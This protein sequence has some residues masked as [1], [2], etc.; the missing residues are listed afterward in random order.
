M[1]IE[2]D[3]SNSPYFDDY[4]SNK[5]YYKVLFKPG[6]AVQVRELNQLQ[7]ILQSQIEKF[8]DN[9]YK[10][11]TIIDGVNFNFIENLP[12]IKIKDNTTTGAISD[13]IL[14]DKNF[15]VNDSNGLRAF[16][17]TYESG[18]ESQD[19]DLNT[20]FI[21]Y[22]NSGDNGTTS[23]Y[24]SGQILSVVDPLRSV[25]S[26]FLN[27]G[28]VGYVN[29]NPVII[30][31]ALSLQNSVG[32]TT[33]TN[34]SAGVSTFTVGE[35]VTQPYSGAKGTVVAIN[36]TAN[37]KSIV[38]QI[39]P[40][41]TDVI[42][43]TATSS[44]W[45]FVEGQSIQG[46][47]SNVTAN[48]VN[49]VGNGASASIITDATGQILSFNLV[50][51]GQ[52]YYVQ[53]QVSVQSNTGTYALLS[54]EALNYIAKITVASTTGSVGNGYAF[55]VSEG[56]IYQ[57]GHFLRVAPQ[58]IIV[59]KYSSTP[60]N[61]VVG[62]STYETL[63][64]STTDTTLLDNATGTYN[65][66]A[67]GADRL[68]LVPQ[69]TVKTKSDSD[70]NSDF[71][72]IVEFNQ[73]RPSKQFQTTQF[74]SI[75]QVMAKRTSETSGDFVT[76]P[77][78]VVTRSVT[79]TS[80]EG[81]TFTIVIDPGVAY[82]SG[83]RLST[84]ANY[85]INVDKGI[86]TAS[87]ANTVVNFS[88]GN[89][90]KITNLGGPFL[91]TTGALIQL[92]STAK[93]FL[94][95]TTTFTAAIT[96]PGAQ[97]GTAR[98]RSL[99]YDGGGPPGT[100]DA[101]YRLYLYN[102][103]MNSSRNFRDV[104]S[105]FY[106]GTNY[107]AVADI[108]LTYDASVGGNVASLLGQKGTMLFDFGR[109][110]IKDT[111]NI[112]YNYRALNYQVPLTNTTGQ[113]T[114]TLAT[115]GEQFPYSLGLLSSGNETDFV[116]IPLANVSAVSNATGNVTTSTTNTT[117]SSDT[118]WSGFGVGD[119]VY[120]A[121]A[122]SNTV[123]RIVSF[124]N[125]S[126]VTVDS[127]CSVAFADAKAKLYFPQNIPVK[128]SGRDDR[129][130]NV[131]SSNTSV[132]YFGNTFGTTVNLAV[133]HTVSVTN[134]S[135]PTKSA[136]R[137]IFVKLNPNTS[138]QGLVGPWSLGVPDAIRLKNVYRFSNS[139]VNTSSTDV[140]NLFYIDSNQNENYY[141]L[142]HLH[143]DPK[144][145]VSISTTDWYL[146]K[147]DVMTK[148]GAGPTTIKSYP[149]DDTKALADLGSNVSIFEVPEMYTTTGDYVDINNVIDF[150]PYANVT[151]NVT[152]NITN[153]T[154]NPSP[155]ASF[156]GTDT[157]TNIQYFPTPDSSLV[158]NVTYYLGRIDKIILDRSNDIKIVRGVASADKL[159]IPDAPS[160][161]LTI[162]NIRVSPYPSI[163]VILSG[164][165]VQIFDKKIVN[166]KFTNTRYAN[167]LVSTQFDPNTISLLQ[168][169]TY[170][171]KE[172]GS[173]ERRI[174]TLEYYGALAF[175]EL[176]TANRV[177]SSSLNPSINRFKF[178]F[179]VDNFS[180][181]TFTNSQSPEYNATIVDGE[182]TSSQDQM[183]L[184]LKSN[185]YDSDTQLSVDG[186]YITLPGEKFTLLSQNTA[187]VTNTTSTVVSQANVCVY[188]H[189]PSFGPKR[190][191][192]TYTFS[193]TSGT[194]TLYFSFG[195]VKDYIE[196]KQGDGT[197]LT[198]TSADAIAL[199]QAEKNELKAM[200]EFK[201]QTIIDPV[202]AAN[203]YVGYAGKII[204]PHNIAGG[205]TYTIKITKSS[206]DS[207]FRYR[208][209]YPIDS[210]N[211]TTIDNH[212]CGTVGT[213]VY[214]G[215]MLVT[216]AS[217]SLIK[218]LE[219]KNN[220]QTLASTT[221]N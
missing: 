109:K 26:I 44:T 115:S 178:G 163:P 198:K 47:T 195:P 101:V 119:Y 197:L 202:I 83:T 209:C 20:L 166:E 211:N 41:Q 33:F 36:T 7:T 117:V 133:T 155:N 94:S 173:L 111:T 137:N 5:D 121:N 98:I 152:T 14:Y 214:T 57:K 180:S 142:S 125:A 75:E 204:I 45:T 66:Q 168:P 134:A 203:G 159:S 113:A 16:I 148:S 103:Q 167:H 170:T 182:V 53:P 156:S 96:T 194:A 193:S 85:E 139:S 190:D 100:P 150:R 31:S 58:N 32:G 149:L 171:M 143:I 87:V 151:A 147:F 56:V 188:R 1:S 60:N 28:S 30:T 13:V 43:G 18:F 161:T 15:L 54:A 22:V 127:N 128:F 207:Q 200:P 185:F 144:S 116:V 10:R 81:N 138:S 37:N 40:R 3:L 221:F 21:R 71:F 122:S 124:A 154:T 69:L 97:I 189:V 27:S 63:V 49:N 191:T 181:G 68:K 78:L 90:V 132:L 208:L 34:A 99:V 105:V 215:T 108:K 164:N 112:S 4:N 135:L 184:P 146:V 17:S 8:G 46:A 165:I 179:F 192:Q 70:A 65:K 216:P 24:A 176:Q 213:G 217:F 196:I 64:S 23:N 126:H 104:R 92:H 72:P 199:T 169:K 19:P 39:K 174:Q 205:R 206:M 11:G 77:F 118:G 130:I 123:K 212:V 48:V 61:L 136:T 25:Q 6:V 160:D 80:L 91:H 52:G 106:D 129:F 50:N 131:S 201:N 55:A 114:L 172:I 140:T 88:Y 67:P 86:D 183:N 74:N 177:I 162:N 84:M 51:K 89:Y 110:S 95:N 158:A 210:L 93:N 62:F 187:T 59:D 38:L 220:S 73:G 145:N 175:L 102:I 76:D 141:N 29:S 107:D 186:R 120:L 153:V 42:N 35:E 219:L 12:Y 79:N 218:K 2:T 157:T 82:V 9:I